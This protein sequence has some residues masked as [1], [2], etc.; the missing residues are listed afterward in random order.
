MRTRM[1]PNCRVRQYAIPVSPGCSV[2]STE[3]Q[4]VVPNGISDI[5]ME[6]PFDW[7]LR[8]CTAPSILFLVSLGG[9][10][11]L[12]V[13]LNFGFFGEHSHRGAVAQ[14]QLTVDDDGV[15]RGNALADLDLAR[16]AQA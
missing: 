16:P 3:D 1:S 13:G 12:A 8:F 14:P 9:L 11:V 10:G 15:A 4:S 6:D 2:R 7:R 5:S